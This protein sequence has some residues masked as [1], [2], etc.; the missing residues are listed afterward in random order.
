MSRPVRVTLPEL[1]ALRL[2]RQHLVGNPLGTPAEVV[3]WL[4]AVQSQDYP[5]AKWALAQRTTG[6]DDSAL[7]ALFDEGKILR[8]HVMR[9]TWHFVRPE[10]LRGL[11]DLTRHRVKAVMASYD[12]KLGLDDAVFAKSHGLLA[13]ALEGERYMT[14]KE[15]GAVLAGGGIPASAHQLAHLMLRA[16]LDAVVVSGPLRGRQFTYALFDERVPPAPPRPREEALADLALR[17]FTSHGPATVH[18]FAWWSGL[19]VTEA[20]AGLERVRRGLEEVTCEGKTYWLS[21]PAAPVSLPEPTLHLLPNYDEHLVA[22]RDHGPSLDPGAPGAMAGWG[23]ALT[24]HLVVRNGLVVGGWRRTVEKQ[25]VVVTPTLLVA[26]SDAERAAMEAEAEAYGRF[27]G[28]PAVL[29][30]S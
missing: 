4:G 27:L 29:A 13:A 18:D 14:R 25:R 15:L 19:T 12:R 10:D 28:L 21:A 20:R 1:A 3:R 9:P 7:D 6:V 23:T 11:L 22:Y 26:L 2:H 16:E 24:A 30:E 5:G 17:Y 8:T